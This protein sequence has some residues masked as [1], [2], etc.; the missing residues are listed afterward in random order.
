MTSELSRRRMLTLGA[1]AVAAT[2]TSGWLGE[3][4]ALAH[5]AGERT[6]TTAVGDTK[7]AKVFGGNPLAARPMARMW[8]P[9]AGAGKDSEGLA[10]VAKQLT[11]MANGGFGGVEIAFLSDNT[12]YDNDDAKEFGWGSENWRRILKQALRT[13]NGAKAG[14]KVDITITSHWPPIVNTVDPND[15]EQQQEASYAYRKITADDLSAGRGDLPLPETRTRDFSNTSSLIADFVFVDKLATATVARVASLDDSGDPVF[16]LASLIDVTAAT[17]RKQETDA[18]AAAKVENGKRYAG[19]A[20]GVPDRA[21]AEANGIDYDDVLAKFGPEPTSSSFKGKID[22]DGNRRRMADWQYHYESDLSKVGALKKY[23]PS[24]GDSLAAG[25]YVLFGTY[26]RGTGQIM[27]GGASVTIHNR[28]YATNYFSAEGVQKIFDFWDAHIL[29]REMISLLKKNGRLGSSIFE[30]SIEIHA[31][32]PLWTPNLLTAFERLNGYDVAK[33][34]PVLALNSSA[35]FDDSETATRIGEDKNL[36]LGDLYETEHASLIKDWT[37]SFGYTYRAQAYTLSGLDIARAASALDIPEGDNSTSG[38]GLRNIS[39]AVNMA[40]GALVSMETTTF[41][42]NINSTWHTVAQ[43]VNRDLSHGVNRSIFHGSAFARSFNG[44]QSSWPGW[45]FW[46][47]SSYNARQI[48]WD[49]VDTFSGYVTRSQTVMQHGNARIDLAVLLGTN[50][51]FSIQS[52]NGFQSLLDKGYSYNLLSESLLDSKSAKV[53]GG[54]LA[55]DGP[56]F[57]TLIV[58]EA[59]RLSVSTVQKLID[60]AGKGLPVILYNTD[61]TRVYGTNKNNNNDTALAQKL[62][63]L[64]KLATV[65]T[66]TTQAEILSLLDSWKVT[67]AA[68]HDLA[69]VEASLRHSS[70]ADY[71]YFY[72]STSAAVSGKVT[73]AGTGVPHLLDAWTGEVTPIAEYVA[74][75]DTV[76]VTIDLEGR[77]AV[78]VALGGGKASRQT[79]A[80][81]VSAGTVRY[82]GKGQLIH[83]AGTAGTSTVSL[84]TGKKQKVTIGSLPDAVS[85]GTGW[86]LALESWGPDKDANTV[87]P[88][89]SARTGI[90][91]TDTSLGDWTDL[92]ATSAQLTRLGVDSMSEVSGIGRY[93]TTFTLPKTWRSNV[94]AL[95]ELAHGDDLVAEVRINGALID[96][97]DQFTDT[98]DVGGLLQAG[99]NALEVKLDTTLGHRTGATTSSQTY[100]LTAVTLTPYVENTL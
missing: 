34:G 70:E 9:D 43:E 18:S 39:A 29:D 22:S 26:R 2:A 23:S 55:A 31:D 68:L 48:W 35:R 52:G 91:F 57:K 75:A 98:I 8:F 10:L 94:G 16:E 81:T 97:V 28:S 46:T 87:D 85:L 4:T 24:S 56:A 41:S 74:D 44:H 20:A 90:S 47:F 13:A 27:S 3:S 51:G 11:D 6:S 76:T 49:D 38:D 45:N 99:R 64:N 15:D 12:S 67:P 69:G 21:Y 60:Y 83:R 5:T 84:S 1:A 77:D 86:K 50:D 42:A 89:V 33:Y 53:S 72:N 96:D 36:V 80:T 40:G 25:D 79:H 73:L 62:A 92:P 58:R 78:I 100:G 30:D 37:D 54:V 65:A 14:F 93:S 95:L 59:T 82:G 71:Y 63:K 88:T 19:S 32:S 61:V 66:A 7:I 17:T